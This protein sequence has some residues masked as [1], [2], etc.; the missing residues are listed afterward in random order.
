MKSEALCG[1]S[2]KA[3]FF[4]RRSMVC[5]NLSVMGEKRWLPLRNSYFQ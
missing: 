2:L 3:V 4:A 1:L 5:S